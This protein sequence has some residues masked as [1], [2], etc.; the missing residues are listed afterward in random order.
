MSA[1]LTPEAE[2]QL[3]ALARK[4]G[5]S[6]ELDSELQEELYGHLEDKALAYLSGEEAVSVDD[7]ILLTREHF[8]DPR[9][10]KSWLSSV[11][12]HEAAIC[13]GRRLAAMA[14]V[15]LA[16][17]IAATLVDAIV[18][19]VVLLNAN[20]SWMVADV[21]LFCPAT[22]NL[23][24]LACALWAASKWRRCEIR[25]GTVWYD[26]WT[27]YEIGIAIPLLLA[28]RW[29]IPFVTP[30]YSL[31]DAL[32]LLSFPWYV[33]MFG[34]VIEYYLWPTLW[35]WWADLPPHRWRACL[36]GLGVCLFL[37][38]ANPFFLFLVG[39]PAIEVG[40]PEG[41]S[42]GISIA[43]HGKWDLAFVQVLGNAGMYLLRTSAAALV[44]YALVRIVHDNVRSRRQ[45][46]A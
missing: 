26:R 2:E 12:R 45:R 19:T 17:Q 33:V 15:M 36:N 35:L 40:G 27:G 43:Y 4:I 21:F 11:H 41:W 44:L 14:I 23:A 31:I 29:A 3:R 28:T 16:A 39:R 22:V 20:S 42:F 46:P 37:G 9:A 6:N 13:T 32:G 34:R 38:L 5:V 1:R 10:L 25:G 7:A 18:K 8:G 24:A 30:H